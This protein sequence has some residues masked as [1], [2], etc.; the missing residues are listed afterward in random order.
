LKNQA[1]ITI[2]VDSLASI[3]KGQGLKRPDG[4]NFI[5]FQTG[6]ETI[7]RFFNE[8][9]I[10]TTLFMVGN[11]FLP[12]P[13]HSVIRSIIQ[14]LHEPANHS[15]THPQGFRWLT[16]EEKKVEISAMGDICEKVTGLR[17]IGFRSPGWNIDD[18]TLPI[19]KQLGY[20]YDSSVFPTSLMPL[21]KFAHWASMS[22]QPKP[23]RTTM[24]MW[25]YM[26]APIKP[27]HTS[28]F[29]LAQKGVGGIIEFPVSV[30]PILRIPFFATLLL[31]TGNWFFK[32]LYKSIQRSGLPV[33]FQMHLSDFVDY[34]IPEL[35][36][37]I[38]STH[39]GAYIPQ[40]LATPLNKKLEVFRKMLD[41]MIADYE[42]ITLG[43]WS[44]FLKDQE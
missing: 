4:Y 14:D 22:G 31:F 37:Q 44:N 19:L 18:R 21:M 43:Q 42:F 2:D 13:N 3:Y 9:Q 15:M 20:V 36:N 29:S 40:A 23:N 11:D 28:Q 41:L 24:G 10:K 39:Q 7:Q 35:D 33:Q 26:T 34:S 17:P 8:Y 27:F 12:Q 16:P 1:S 6:L 25:R 30:S 38:P 5:E 32:A